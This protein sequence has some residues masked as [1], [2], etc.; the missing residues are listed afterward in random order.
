MGGAI[1]RQEAGIARSRSEAWLP[2][3]LGG[4]F[5]LWFALRDLLRTRGLVIDGL[6]VWGRDFVNVWTGG[7]LVREGRLST[8]TDVAAYQAFQQ[9]LFGF[10]GQHNYSYPPVTFPVAALL[11]YLP[12]WLALV[13]W[14][15]VGG[16][17]FI[18]AAKPWWPRQ[19]GPEWLAVLTPAALLNIWAGHYGFFIG[20]LLLTGW[21]QVE[22]RR[23]TLAGLCFGLM[24]IKPHLAVLV[25]LAL[26]M[27]REW[28]VIAVAAVTALGLV[29]VTALVYG[30][31]PWL[32]FLFGTSRVQAS[33][34]DPH[35]SFFGFMSTS[36]ATAAVT[37]SG[38]W[39]VALTVQTLFAA[40]AVWAVVA[41]GRSG[42]DL[43]SYAL[44]TATA[45][46]LVLPYAFNYDLTVVMIGAAAVMTSAC[47]SGTDRRLALYGFLAPQLGM[48]MSGFGAPLM[49]LFIAGLLVAQFRQCCGGRSDKHS[50]APGFVSPP[51]NQQQ[52]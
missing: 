30:L 45:T 21:R 9:H 35:G 6:D 46:F 8:L 43:R 7:H 5:I 18:W 19:A 3:A 50:A 26:A 29:A 13:A 27:R 38:S 31:Q 33:L 24:I 49:P 40:G 23:P 32:E 17:F 1:G 4:I 14:Q 20:G 2:W 52:A 28:K 47:A 10:T 11:S 48:V 12:Y 44:L 37:L 34:I 39:S 25:P 16:A 36:A 42:A 15:V 51:F 22:L 41:T